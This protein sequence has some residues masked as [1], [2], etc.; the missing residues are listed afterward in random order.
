MTIAVTYEADEVPPNP[1]DVAAVVNAE[2]E[3]V[4]ETRRVEGSEC[5]IRAPH[6]PVNLK[7][8]VI[9]PGDIAILVDTVAECS[10]CA[11]SVNDGDRSIRVTNKAP[12]LGEAGDPTVVTDT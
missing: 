3:R 4:S 2:A 1:Y 9:I 8:W 7:R 11:W 6:E 10:Q 12:T 5:P